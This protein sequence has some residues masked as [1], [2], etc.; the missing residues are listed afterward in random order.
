MMLMMLA[1]RFDYY[2]TMRLPGKM[3]RLYYFSPFD[4]RVNLIERY[5][6]ITILA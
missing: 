2:C 1:M 4:A 6:I 5:F 3:A